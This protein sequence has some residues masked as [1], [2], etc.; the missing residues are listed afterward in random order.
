MEYKCRKCKKLGHN[1]RKCPENADAA[2]SNRR[3]VESTHHVTVNP[4][5]QEATQQRDAANTYETASGPRN[6][7]LQPQQ[8]ESVYQPQFSIVGTPRASTCFTTEPIGGTSACLTDQI[9]RQPAR[10]QPSTQPPRTETGP[11]PRH[12]NAKAATTTKTTTAANGLN[13]SATNKA[14]AA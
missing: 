8:E 6:E 2:N 10:S 5:E 14:I 11:S 9:P 13:D 4:H 7:E 12:K 3:A 1:S